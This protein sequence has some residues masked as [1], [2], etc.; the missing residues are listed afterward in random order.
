VYDLDVRIT[1]DCGQAVF[2]LQQRIGDL[3]AVASCE[4]VP[5]VMPTQ[6]LSLKPG[7]YFVTKRLSVHAPART[8]YVSHYLF[9]NPA[10]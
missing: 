8:Q 10:S 1:D 6:T 9:S 3:N 7:N 2:Q 5:F 4:S